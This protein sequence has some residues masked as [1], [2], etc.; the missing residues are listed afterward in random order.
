MLSGSLYYQG[1][2]HTWSGPRLEQT[3]ADDPGGERH[4]RGEEQPRPQPRPGAGAHPGEAPGCE[5]ASEA[6][7]QTEA[8]PQIRH[9]QRPGAG[10][11]RDPGFVLVNISIIAFT[12]GL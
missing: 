7:H 2:I 1:N 12:A 5:R 4:G 6:G 8:T 3:G 10:G 9:Y 11:G